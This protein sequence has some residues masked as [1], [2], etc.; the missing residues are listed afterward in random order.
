M[1]RIT[2]LLF[3]FLGIISLTLNGQ[4]S[5]EY[6]YEPSPKHPFGLA[7]PDAP[8]QIK[9]YAQLIGR[10]KCKSVSRVSNVWTD[11]VHMEWTYKYIMNGLAI[12]DET[13]K[14]DGTHSG[15]IRQF[16]IDS[17]R[18]YVHYYS[19]KAAPPQLQAWE[20]NLNDQGE[21]ILYSPQKAP[22][23]MEG[24]YKIRFFDI[25]EKGFNW[26]GAWVDET[27]TV[28]FPLWKIFCACVDR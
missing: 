19:S 21:M 2:Y 7:N 6:N 17:T 1:K 16:N 23:G 12:K 18:W 22:N 24:Y 9:D 25:S 8:Q 27:E 15:S 14:E 4:S 20:G 5:A 10:H 3:F 28:S 26:I 11:T 13:L